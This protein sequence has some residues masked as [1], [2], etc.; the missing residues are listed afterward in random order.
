MW[1]FH[2][3]QGLKFIAPFVLLLFTDFPISDSVPENEA[4]LLPSDSEETN[5]RCGIC[6]VVKIIWQMP[7]GRAIYSPQKIRFIRR[8]LVDLLFLF[9]QHLFFRWITPLYPIWSLEALTHDVPQPLTIFSDHKYWLVTQAGA[10]IKFHLLRYKD[11][12]RNGYIT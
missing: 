5:P 2:K 7:S 1:D 3:N 11:L 8:Q 6:S 12:F 4:Q 9:C 10:I